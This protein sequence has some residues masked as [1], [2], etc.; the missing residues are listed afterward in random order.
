MQKHDM[1]RAI[2]RKRDGKPLSARE[3]EWIVAGYMNGDVDD[4]QMASLAMACVWRGLTVDETAALAAAMVESGRTLHYGGEAIVLD[5]HSSGGVGDVVTLIAV[6]IVAACGVRVAKLSGRALGHTGGTID[7][8]ETLEGFNAT[9]SPEAFAAC[10][11]RVGCAIAAQSDDLVPADRRI[12]ELR[13]RTGTV[14]SV[15]LIAASIVSKKIAGGANAFAFDVKC[16]SAAFMKEPRGATEL[17]RTLVEIAGRFG[18]NARAIVSRMDEPLGRSIGTGIEVIE[19]RDILT[20]A[21]A[22]GRAGELSLVVAGAMLELAG[23][24]EP[25]I[26]ASRAL[27]SGAAFEKFVEMIAAQGSSADALAR[28]RPPAL[29]REHVA[30]RSGFL[31]AV[32]AAGMG[33]IA[34]IW[35]ASEPDAGI[36]VLA[37]IGDRLERG[38]VL[39]ETFGS[40]ADDVRLSEFFHLVDAPVETRPLVLATV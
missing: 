21:E 38:D 2:E 5:K 4:A 8:L 40:R 18:R 6:P 36:R 25:R 7:K 31:G 24:P 3:W 23:V 30:E 19:A 9:P 34:R 11:E 26:A 27:A 10:V 16:G 15:G 29:R 39:A 1:R 37:R 33:D 13:D 35:T 32:D 14:P 17:A 22:G 12:Y 20:G 28:M